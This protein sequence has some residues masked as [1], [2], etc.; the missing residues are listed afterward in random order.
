MTGCVLKETFV[1]SS[2]FMTFLVVFGVIDFLV[3]FG[4]IDHRNVSGSRVLI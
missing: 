2:T 1:F 4:V 3:V